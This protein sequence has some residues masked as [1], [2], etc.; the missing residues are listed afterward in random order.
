MKASRQLI[1][2]LTQGQGDY[3]EISQV[4]GV[5]K[6]T[7]WRICRG[8]GFQYGTAFKVANAF[9][10]ADAHELFRR[11]LKQFETWKRLRRDELTGNAELS[12][13]AKKR[14]RRALWKLN[15][16]SHKNG[17][18][19]RGKTDDQHHDAD[20]GI[21]NPVRVADV[22][23]AL[24]T[25]RGHFVKFLKHEGIGIQK[26]PYLTGSRIQM[27]NVISKDD[28]DRIYRQVTTAKQSSLQW[29]PPCDVGSGLSEPS[30][31]VVQSQKFQM[32]GG[33]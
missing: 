11:P 8:Q 12:S 33:V 14:I 30:A 15:N 3:N 17:R 26:M 23:S 28:A 18:R 10:Y 27:V 29:Q 24:S 13:E 5:S 20:H 6:P 32:E 21:V 19:W 31:P 16:P 22:A 9:P 25:D 2:M 7:A 4:L 1:E